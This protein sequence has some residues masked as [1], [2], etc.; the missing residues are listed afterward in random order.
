MAG[1][2]D[3]VSVVNVMPEPGVSCRLAPFTEE[4]RHQAMLLRDA[5]AY[6]A[7]RG[8]AVRRGRPSWTRPMRP[9]RPPPGSGRT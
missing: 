6:L 5:T 8:I 9:W 4:R 1:P 2:A 7:D 3:E